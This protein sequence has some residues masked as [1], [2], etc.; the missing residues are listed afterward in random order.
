MRLQYKGFSCLI[1]YNISEKLAN[2]MTAVVDTKFSIQN[3]AMQEIKNDENNVLLSELKIQLE[4][5]LKE[6]QLRLDEIFQRVAIRYVLTLCFI[7]GD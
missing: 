3:I 5:L 1:D 7:I 6:N 4:A 2:Y